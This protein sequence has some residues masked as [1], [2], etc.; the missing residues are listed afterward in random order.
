MVAIPRQRIEYIEAQADTVLRTAYGNT[1]KLTFPVDVEKVAKDS[2]LEILEIQFP[3]KEVAGAYNKNEKRIYVAE[4]DY[5]PRQLFTIA[6]ELG[7]FFLHKDKK[8]E[9]FLRTDALRVG[10]EGNEKAQEEK[11]ADWFAASL[12]M[13]KESVKNYWRVLGNTKQMADLFGVSQ[14]EM[15]W[16]LVNIGVLENSND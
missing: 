6:H 8:E 1:E 12:L 7:H 2:G 5:F 9:V 16:R 15:R 3:Q 4:N 11:E 14:S 13:P 10:I